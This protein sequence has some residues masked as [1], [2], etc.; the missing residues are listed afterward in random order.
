MAL[1]FLYMNSTHWNDISSWLLYMTQDIHH[2]FH[3]NDSYPTTILSYAELIEHPIDN[4][5]EYRRSVT[6]GAVL[7]PYISLFSIIT[8]NI[9]PYDNVKKIKEEFLS[10]CNFQVFFLDESSENLITH[11]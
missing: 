1:F 6:K 3:Q 11:D 5:N 10:H 7:Y 2:L 4:S 9:Q 8:N